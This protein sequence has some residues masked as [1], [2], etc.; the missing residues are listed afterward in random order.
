MDPK[1]EKKLKSAMLSILVLSGGLLLL[2]LIGHVS[3]VPLALFETAAVAKVATLLISGTVLYGFFKLFQYVLT[4]LGCSMGVF[5]LAGLPLT[6][7]AISYFVPGALFVFTVGLL[8][9]LVW[10]LFLTAGV[11]WAEAQGQK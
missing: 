5:Q 4:S 11:F 3:L 10:S 2:T 7:L 6:A 8:W 9:Q 1:T